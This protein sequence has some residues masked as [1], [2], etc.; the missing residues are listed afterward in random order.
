[1]FSKLFT[2]KTKN[3]TVKDN[4]IYKIKATEKFYLIEFKGTKE[5]QWVSRFE[6]ENINRKFNI[7][8]E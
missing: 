2:R 4:D 8:E 7:E 6:L 5:T 1:M 3:I